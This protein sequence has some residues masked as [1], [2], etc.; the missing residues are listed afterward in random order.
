MYLS[1]IIKSNYIVNNIFGI[2]FSTMFISNGSILKF[3]VITTRKN[4]MNISKIVGLQ[5]S[6]F[7]KSN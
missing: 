6:D 3:Q 4:R 1:F 2:F 5:I 7:S